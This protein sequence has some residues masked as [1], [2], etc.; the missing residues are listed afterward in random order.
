MEKT[1]SKRTDKNKEAE[2]LSLARKK[3]ERA[4]MM[5]Y[6]NY[7][8]GLRIH[9]GKIVA[10]W[11]VDD[12][13]T[14]TFL[15]AFLHIDSYDPAKSEFRT[16]LYTIGWNTALDHLGRKQRE[17]ENMPTS[18]I[19]VD[20]TG[21]SAARIPDSAKGPE[22]QISN[23]EDYQKALA[24]IE[25]LDD[26]YRDIAKDRFINEC[27]YNEIAE[28]YNLPI[29]TVKTRIKRAREILI[30]MMETSDEIM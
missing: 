23:Q 18:S 15:K 26:L 8:D 28:K 22:D 17:K 27:E 12:V 9:V 5:L 24:Y 6:N 10:S 4:F 2:I 20:E 21:N 3:N 16:W 1:G 7:K 13:C 19:D 25:E 14:Q 29:N 30:R 11:D